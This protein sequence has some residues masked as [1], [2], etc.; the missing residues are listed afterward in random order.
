MGYDVKINLKP[1]VRFALALFVWALLFSFKSIFAVGLA[2][3]LHECAHLLMCVALKVRVVG[4]TPLPWGLTI[5]TPLIYDI[6]SQLLI[7]A[8]GPACNFVI[9]AVCAALRTVSGISGDYFELFMLANLADGL[10]NLLPVLP[11]DGGI[12][13]KSRLCAVYGLAGGFLKSM[14]ITAFAG[15]VIFVI[16][17]QI[18]LVTGYNFSYAAAGLFVLVNLRHERE[19]LMCI[20]KRI[21]TGEIKSASKIKYICVDSSCH[22]LCLANLI[23][24]NHTLIFLVNDNGRFAGELTQEE[25]IKKLLQNS[26][27][28]AGECVE[29]F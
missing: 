27:I 9:L 20:K 8:S 16:G 7:S 13:L 25:L 18:F 22:A 14:R 11:L 4:M 19:L 3:L 1:C 15:A 24:C 17:I 28:T 29:K 23:S 2:V 5:S 6:K 12:I 26:L 10:L 21:Y